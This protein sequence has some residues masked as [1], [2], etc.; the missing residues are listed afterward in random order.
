M[1]FRA[2]ILLTLL[3]ICTACNTRSEITKPFLL[4]LGVNE[5][6]SSSAKSGGHV[7]ADG[8]SPVTARGIVWGTAPDPAVD[9]HTGMAESEAGTGTFYALLTGLDN[10]MRYYVRAY[11]TNSQGISYGEN[12]SFM[13]A[14]EDIVVVHTRGNIAPES[15][16]VTYRTIKSSL[17]GERKCWIIQNLGA[18]HPAVSGTDDSPESAGWYWQFN[19]KQGFSDSTGLV[20]P[21][22]QWNEFIE[23]N[24][25]WLADQDPCALLLG[26]EWRMPTAGEWETVHREGKWNSVY[27]TYDSEL[28][29]HAAGLI[30]PVSGDPGLRGVYGAYW[31][32]S[33]F[34]PTYG[35]YLYFYGGSSTMYHYA[36]SNYTKSTGM[37]VRCLTGRLYK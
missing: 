24:A 17:T 7:Y 2:F 20:L 36:F 30:D 32:S 37:S 18:E 8:S 34:S 15:K 28:K 21:Q 29:V 4:T 16:T 12:V 35:K 26:S 19:R 31:T 6:S 14:C 3:G 27:H 25:G 1:L 11:A 23:E 9:N 13:T 22:T 10:M 5:I 33:E